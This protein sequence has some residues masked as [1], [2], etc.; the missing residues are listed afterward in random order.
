MLLR[1]SYVMTVEVMLDQSR[2]K[3]SKP[4]PPLPDPK[5]LTLWLPGANQQRGAR[6]AV[7]GKTNSGRNCQVK[8]TNATM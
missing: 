7:I 4:M 5:K 1:E 8:V 2:V 6:T 3:L